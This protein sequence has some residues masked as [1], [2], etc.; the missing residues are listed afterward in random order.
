MDWKTKFE[1][2]QAARKSRLIYL[3]SAAS[4]PHI[5]NHQ[6]VW[7]YASKIATQNLHVGLDLEL[8]GEVFKINVE[9]RVWLNSPKTVLLA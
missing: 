2:I 5:L 9:A 8:L 6:C 7:Q 1:V 4:R 3:A